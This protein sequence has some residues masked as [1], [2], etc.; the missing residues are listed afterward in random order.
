MIV[1]IATSILMVV[2]T[3]IVTTTGSFTSPVVEG[4]KSPSCF[5]PRK[6]ELTTI[7]T[8]L[9]IMGAGQV[10]KPEPPTF[11]ND[12]RRLIPD[13]SYKSANQALVGGANPKTLIAPIIAAPA[14][15]DA[16]WST[17]GFSRRSDINRAAPFDLYRSG[18]TEKNVFEISKC[19]ECLYSPCVCL[20]GSRDRGSRHVT[21]DRVD[22][23][24]RRD[25][26]PHGDIK[27]SFVRSSPVG[28]DPGDDG[29]E[30]FNDFGR[31]YTPYIF[32]NVLPTDSQGCQVSLDAAAKIGTK[33]KDELLTQIIQPG[34]YQK[35][36]V[37][38]PVNSM[39]GI[40]F[41]QGFLPTE[42]ENIPSSPCD[43]PALKFTQRNPKGLNI[44]VQRLPEWGQDATNV[45]DPRFTGYGD[46]S[47]TYIDETTG[48]P[49]FYYRDVDSVIRPNYIIRSDVDVLPWASTYGP[50]KPTGAYDDPDDYSGG[51]T[52][53]AD[54]AFHQSTISFR[55]EMQERLMRRR[56]AEM[57]QLRVAPKTNMGQLG[58]GAGR[59]CL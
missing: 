49:R 51:Y 34:V 54:N 26:P 28:V 42:V 19:T 25:A 1:K 22:G 53:L 15:D 37:G 31:D 2:L 14:F 12:S 33:Y 55:T 44:P 4:F 52:K 35:T 13:E 21:D 46:A 10:F 29:R 56:N 18:F 30:N 27:E 41:N 32:H 16:R 7:P 59:S 11:C 8:V 47:R 39:I 58:N 23:D 5:A 3:I 20:I 9:P 38:E 40:S 43:D 6:I 45:F 24:R 57:W 17:D 36:E 48:R 50:D